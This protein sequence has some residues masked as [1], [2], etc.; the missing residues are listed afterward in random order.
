M[1]GVAGNPSVEPQPV[2]GSVIAAGGGASNTGGDSVTV[3]Q[4]G[5]TAA[6]E[7]D[8]RMDIVVD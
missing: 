8:S 2:S 4:T 1:V 6:A 5:D 3:L 7:E